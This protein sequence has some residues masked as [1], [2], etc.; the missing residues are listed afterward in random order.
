MYRTRRLAPFAYVLLL[1]FLVLT[2]ALGSAAPATAEQ[3][4]TSAQPVAPAGETVSAG[5]VAAH[6][7]ILSTPV[8]V[9][10]L[11]EKRTET[12]RTY[13]LSDG[14]K[15]AE[16]FQRPINYQDAN[17][18]WQPIDAR[19][20]PGSLPGTYESA[21]TA[22]K[23]GISLDKAKAQPLVSL[24]YDGALVTLRPVAFPGM[25]RISAPSVV[26][27]KAKFGWAWAGPVLSYEVIEEGVKET[28]TLPSA[29]SPDTYVF[30]ID[31]AGL[32]LKQDETGQWG[33]YKPGEI[34][35]ALVLGDLLVYDS[36]IDETGSP[37]VAGGAEMTL[38][39]G[40]DQSTATI[41]VPKE[42]LTDPSRVFPVVIDPTVTRYAA[43]DTYISSLYPNTSY[44]S[45]TALKVGYYDA[46]TGWNKAL[47]KFYLPSDLTDGG[48]GYVIS[49]NLKLYQHLQYYAGQAMPTHVGMMTKT[50]TGLSTWNSLGSYAI[51][52]AKT[53]SVAM[54]TWLD[55]PCADMVQKWASGIASNYGFVV[56]QMPATEGQTYWRQFRSSEY[57]DVNYRP[58]LVINYT[59]V[60]DVKAD[61]AAVGDGTH[62]DTTNIQNAI[63]AAA[64]A[65]GGRVFF[66]AGTYRTTQPLQLDVSYVTLE[67]TGAS[68]VLK[69]SGA[70]QTEVV[71][72]GSNVGAVSGLSVKSLGIQVPNGGYGVKV[73]G[74]GGGTTIAIAY[75]TF[76]GALVDNESSGVQADANFNN[77]TVLGNDF[78]GLGALPLNLTVSW[79]G[80]SVSGNTLPVSQSYRPDL[81]WGANR[82][83]TAVRLS[84]AGYPNGAAAAVLVSGEN[85]P[86]ALSV[87]P[88]AVAYDGP[89][90][91]TYASALTVDTA[92]ELRRLNPS[93]VFVVGLG[94]TVQNA[95]KEA[96]PTATVTAI[97][98][99]DRYDT[100]A[101]VAVQLKAKLG[102]V[103]KVVVVPG[104]N[105][106]DGLTVGPL[107]AQKG[108]A[109]LLTPAAGPLPTVTYN[110]YH[111]TL[112]V[113]S[114]LEV[115]TSVAL[116]YITNLTQIT[117]SDRYDTSTHV[118]EYAETLDG[119]VVFNHMGLATGDN[120]P[121]ALAV[122]SYL[123]KDDG[124][125]LLTNG[126]AATA[127]VT[128]EL[129]DHFSWLDELTY[130]ALPNSW[131]ADQ[132]SG[133]YREPAPQHTAYDLGEFADHDTTA[134]LDRGR[135]N[136][137]TVDLGIASFGPM[138][139]LDRTYSSG[140]TTAGYFAPGWRF[141]FERSLTFV[142]ATL[143]RYSDEA[144][145]SCAFVKSD[146]ASSV[147]SP[148][149]GMSAKLA[150][151]TTNWTLTFPGT[152]AVLTFD[153]TSGKLLSEADRNG[154][155]VTYTW[156]SGYCTAITA[157]NGQ[158]IQLTLN[159]SHK[160]TQA[161]YATAHGTR[162][163]SYAT[164]APWTIT[165][166][167]GTSLSHSLT[168]SYNGSSQLSGMT[169]T[170][171]T[172]TTAAT[173][174]FLYT[175]GAL[176]EVRFPDYTTVA[177]FPDYNN[178]SSDAKATIAYNGQS[179]T[180]SRWGCVYA[181]TAPTGQTGT[182]VVK[183]VSWD[184]RGA[185]VG[186]TNFKVASE[187]GN[188]T[189]SY[190]LSALNEAVLVT[191][192]PL[193]TLYSASYTPQLLVGS[194]TDAGGATVSVTYGDPTTVNSDLPLTVTDSLGST[195]YYGY[196]GA[197]NP[198][199][200]T[201]E[202]TEEGDLGVTRCTYAN[203]TVGSATYRGALV[204]ERKLI[205]GTAQNGIWAVTDYNTDG[206]YPNGQPKKTVYRDVALYDGQVDP[207]DL[208]VT[209]SYD[210]LGNLL[211][212]TDTSGQVAETNTYDLAGRLLTSTGPAFTATVSGSPV[213]TQVV[214]HNVYDA[215]GHLVESYETSSVDT[216]GTKANWT[217]TTYD[218]CGRARQVKTWLF[219]SP[220]PSATP[221]N[222][223]TF[224]YDGL[225][226]QIT[227]SD[228]T[229]SG[230]PSLSSYDAQ[231]NVVASWA[232]RACSTTYDLV[233]A[234]RSVTDAG[235]PAY[236]ALGNALRSAPPGGNPTT[237]TYYD[238]GQIHVETQPDGTSITY[239]YDEAG[240]T[241]QEVS[242]ESGTISYA[243]DLASC[244]LS[245]TTAA[246][247]TTDFG[248][249]LLGQQVSAGA[250]GQAS[251]QVTYNT[252][253]WALKTADA[254]GFTST[255]TYDAAGQVVS[256]AVQGATTLSTYDFAGHLTLQADP[257]DR[258]T[259]ITYDLFGR[260]SE[261]V[262]TLPGSPRVLISD[263]VVVFD[264]LGRPTQSTD[265]VRGLA[266]SYT[267]PQNTPSVT[268]EVSAVGATGSGLVTSAVSI[269][270]NGL[271]VSRSVQVESSP[272]IPTILRSVDTRDTAQ[273]VTK[274][275][276]DAGAVTDIYAQ[277]L[278]DSAGRLQ[279]QWG[280]STGAGSGY[281][282]TAP[283]TNAY[284]YSPAT[285]LKTADN[286]Q[287]Q[288]VGIAG[289]IVSSYTYTSAG[290]LATATTN[291]VTETDT[292]DPSGNITSIGAGT[293]LTYGE[294]G[295]P[296]NQLS[297]MTVGGVTICFT[298]DATKRWRTAQGP[299]GNP[300]AIAF[301]YTGTGRLASYYDETRNLTATYSYDANG[302]RTHSQ[303]VQTGQ[304]TQETDFIYEGITLKS[305]SASKGSA[306]WKI[307]YLY[308]EAG[309]LYGGVYRSPATST[310][311][312]FFGVVTTDRGDVVELL[313]AAGNPFVAYRYDAWGNP[314][315]S[316]NVGTGI[317]SQSTG[318]IT[319]Q[320]ATDIAS[321]Q[322]LKYASYCLDSESGMYYLS[323]RQYDPMT[324]QFLSKDPAKDDGEASA[325]QYC[326]GDPVGSCDPSGTKKAKVLFPPYKGWG[327]RINCTALMKEWLRVNAGMAR[328]KLIEH[329]CTF[330]VTVYGAQ[331]LWFA[332][333][334]RKNGDWDM[335]LA[336]PVWYRWQYRYLVLQTP[337]G[338]VSISP[339]DF[340]NVHF[341]YTGRWAGFS[342][343]QLKYFGTRYAG[344]GN[345]ERDR[346]MVN[347]GYR[348]GGAWGHDYRW[349]WKVNEYVK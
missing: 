219:G 261:T 53:I 315:G 221:A 186:E 295:T 152:G 172:G 296:P 65:G 108:W 89:T 337:W 12:S 149:S 57:S 74:A 257:E 212:R 237:Y 58:R 17:G 263:A 291:G 26:G 7:E 318:L 50:W 208:T 91:L 46:T 109:I 197:G 41:T 157:A 138:A 284:T 114:A 243:Y 144:G 39:V 145:E 71:A 49:A 256:E 156:S 94:T 176:T 13:L 76:T 163:V 196:D 98:G 200:V 331:G 302:Q 85:Y 60:Y 236:D 4:E 274:A 171:F 330:G 345:E 311:P 230:L 8:P 77:V 140:V 207:P 20:V 159:A 215:W 231:G 5:P 278:Y 224:A 272:Q 245:A 178:S 279:R 130:V 299:Q 218:T 194:T 187:S 62:D 246:G 313:D 332:D 106:P 321:R 242:S 276:I 142:D 51:T 113:S 281:L 1:V 181:S 266:H 151:G 139:A 125:L 262:Q 92:S 229:I 135:L 83:D 349:P 280:P 348:L 185:M 297:T 129:D 346:Q 268:S 184:S 241:S 75:N 259:D 25:G 32:A 286:L 2:F 16:I 44:N 301:S 275:T 292:F 264:S 223:L 289:S 179:A 117:G 306:S 120:Y 30:A 82:Y 63:D 177:T 344:G 293:S 329:G 234:T 189:W 232:S 285:G 314:Q 193:T 310:T 36:S 320:V 333:K 116:P 267:Y 190:T 93:Q 249:D 244:C 188:Q 173:E 300:D 107:A 213:S 228:S 254:D 183:S 325:Y 214:S 132:N 121:D 165:C 162:Q 298:F 252:Q 27:T 56:Y 147:W 175:S 97:V 115:G 273:R 21:S 11:T 203:V 110:C 29:G 260:A 70:S 201:K 43:G 206:Y 95:V 182:Q 305:L 87:A 52:D 136:V 99:T 258:Q 3:G 255:R 288:S 78:S 66:P 271:E 265:S 343:T 339:E 192:T 34:T 146:P 134:T 31:H 324:R 15:Q 294:N 112:G 253:G 303:V 119:K 73:T 239:T 283:S 18:H 86:D 277:Y 328:K 160:L 174:S 148:P 233:K 96:L 287:L 327:Y 312:V 40:K 45:A 269:G 167:P 155:A 164:A 103:S 342:L 251:S 282:S 211:T 180:I 205:S 225:G 80:R 6:A 202:L 336:A 28:I 153:G 150:H 335:K 290:R 199:E 33:L 204:Q 319:S 216:S 59:T 10:E 308:D 118:A 68:S 154:N 309:R 240:N 250:D 334:V 304:D 217:T 35:P 338:R 122:G 166:Y 102:T 48:G 168:Y 222:T 248:Y 79:S 67:G 270:T 90:L 317:W 161:T 131:V 307:T 227:E 19:L 38:E 64:A 84:K 226:R 22:V 128:A 101:R 133:L 81:L 340:G 195:T 47:V 42:W 24:A 104:D 37:A 347:L 220:P 341:G 235:S 141:G 55:L 323:A 209:E 14:T 23:V 9:R 111:T 169:A 54:N 100:A 326:A 123:G 170:N 105:Y 61:Y 238:S 316:G 126:D 127:S 72:I 322:V 88:L 210:A 143:T 124:L 191:T 69:A 158:Q 247:L 198:T 137:G